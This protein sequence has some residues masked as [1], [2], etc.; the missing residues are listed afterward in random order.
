MLPER[1][2][3]WVIGVAG[4][5]CSGKTTVASRFA[6]ELNGQE[7]TAL[8]Q[9]RDF[10]F[11]AYLTDDCP[12]KEVEGHMW[13]NWETPAGIDFAKFVERV[14]GARDDPA[15]PPYVVVEGFQL[16]ALPESRALFDAIVQIDVPDLT[17]WE[18]RHARALSMACWPPGFSTGPGPE[19]NYEVLETY[20]TST[21][22]TAAFLE[23]AAERYG[24]DGD[25]AWLR[26]YFDEVIQPEMASQS[27]DVDTA[28]SE[29]GEGAVLRVDAT[30]PEG[31]EEWIQAC[32]RDAVSFVRERLRCL[33]PDA[34]VAAR[35]DTSVEQG[36]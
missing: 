8:C 10:R 11:D 14:Q 3:P 13:K 27:Q 33:E 1:R 35:A 25:L 9:D 26:V 30:T 5:S 6:A 15:S 34:A 20:V 23:A 28:M 29:L 18:R 17:C 24:A 36:G 4:P 7:A 21:A 16:L 2:R 22:D 19:R 32:V 12:L 31:K